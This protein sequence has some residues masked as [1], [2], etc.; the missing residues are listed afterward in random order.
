MANQAL[1]NLGSKY[2]NPLADDTMCAI[3]GEMYAYHK[4]NRGNLAM[5]YMGVCSGFFHI[6]DSKG[7][8][9]V[10]N[11]PYYTEGNLKMARRL[12]ALKEKYNA[13]VTQIVLGFF[14]VQEF[15]CVPLYGAKTADNL[16]E[17][18]GTFD[19]RFDK[20]DYMF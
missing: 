10:K 20:E 18:A 15:P 14:T 6:Y 12:A 19:I 9:G 8:E 16:K 3:D 4:E 11:S 5:P 1:L 7:E 17:A 2:M 13:T